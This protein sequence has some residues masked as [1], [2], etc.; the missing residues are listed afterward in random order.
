[1]TETPFTPSTFSSALW[2]T[3]IRLNPWS[4]EV[5]RDVQ[6][7]TALHRTLMRLFP[8][9]LGEEA[10][11]EAGLLF[12]YERRDREHVVLLQ[13]A[14]RPTLDRLPDQYGEALTKS[15]APLLDRLHK[16]T[17]VQYTITANATRRRSGL[18][19]DGKPAGTLRPLHGP[20]AEEWWRRRAETAG[21]AVHTA[22]SVSLPDAV[23][24]RRDRAGKEH[25][26]LH[27]RTR[28]DGT[29]TITDAALLVEHLRTGIGRGKSYGCGLLS[30]H[31][32]T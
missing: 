24:D 1:M 11:R 16:G 18:S 3:R 21:L 14:L 23:G 5:H 25:R 6:D 4:R 32:A 17:V 27:A 15:L 12:R 20:E 9:N 29:A 2:L 7:V 19:P 10:R 31:P 8:S 22:D 13:S 26:I 28:F 30:V